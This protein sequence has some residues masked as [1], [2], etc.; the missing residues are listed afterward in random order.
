MSKL[1]CLQRLLLACL[2]GSLVSCAAIGRI[3]L[4]T[5]EKEIEIGREVAK[6]IERE[7]K[8]YKDPLV[9]AYIN[10]LGQKLAGHSLRPDVKYH[11]KVVDTDDVNA[12]AVPGGWL[13]VNRGLITTAENESELAGVLSHEI[14]HVERKHGA[15]A[16]SRQIG[17]AV[18]VDAILGGKDA[19][20]KRRVIGQVFAFS[21]GTLQLKYGR[22]AERE[23]DRFAVE[24]TY[25]AGINPEGMATFFEKLMA[26]R[27][28]EP[29]ML[30]N[31][32]STHPP[33]RERVTNVRSQIHGLTPKPGLTLDSLKF[34]AIK[35]WILLREKARRAKR[36]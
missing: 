10:G 24:A 20:M 31:L 2:A 35:K 7:L 30:A 4:L 22:D 16:L 33:S 36:R 6:E 23:A 12:F 5:T 15:R 19:S 32:F 18:V 25:A 1:P 26:M 14:G 9:T 34:Q 11:F 13:Y 28:K 3:N 17:I 21:S 29:G 8:L 27:K